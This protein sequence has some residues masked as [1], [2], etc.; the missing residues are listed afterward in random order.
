VSPLWLATDESQVIRTA[1]R[2]H[3]KSG[4]EQSLCEPAQVIKLEFH[5]DPLHG[6]HTVTN[7]VESTHAKEL[8]HHGGRLAETPLTRQAVKQ[9]PIIA[10]GQLHRLE[11]VKDLGL[12]VFCLREVFRLRVFCIYACFDFFLSAHQESFVLPV[13]EG[14]TAH[15]PSPRAL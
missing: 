2:S 13:R 12:R 11:E 1:I 5:V 10:V 9:L 4:L 6:P 3:F 7:A 8:T 14:G 15:V